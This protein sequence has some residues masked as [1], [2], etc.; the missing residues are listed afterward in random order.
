MGSA[1]FSKVSLCC[2]QSFCCEM[3]VSARNGACLLMIGEGSG[4]ERLFG[5]N[6]VEIYINNRRVLGSFVVNQHTSGL[7]VGQT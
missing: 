3:Q 6:A 1:S 2:G 4:I 5:G 7:L